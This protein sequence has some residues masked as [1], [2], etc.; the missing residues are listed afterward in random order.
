MGHPCTV[1]INDAH[2]EHTAVAVDVVL[3]E[4]WPLMAISPR[5][6]AHAAAAID[7]RIGQRRLNPIGVDARHHI[8][9]A[10]TKRFECCHIVAFVRG[11]EMMQQI[12]RGCAARDLDGMNVG[13]DPIGRLG[14][15]LTSS[16]IGHCNEPQRPAL[17]RGAVLLERDEVSVLGGERL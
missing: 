16:C 7:R 1:W 9:G 3:H 8:E 11:G 4:A 15:R 12:Q 14:V 17:E 10:S 2:G 6:R 13:V 5:P